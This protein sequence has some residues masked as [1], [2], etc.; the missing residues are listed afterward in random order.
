MRTGFHLTMMRATPI[1]CVLAAVSTAA[2]VGPLRSMTY[3]RAVNFAFSSESS[4]YSPVGAFRGYLRYGHEVLVVDVDT[5]TI[6]APGPS[7]PQAPIVVRRLRVSAMLATAG[8]ARWTA[9]SESPSIP[10]VDSLRLGQD[11]VLTRI[12]FTVS[13]PANIDLRDAWLVF[14]LEGL[15]P[16]V[17]SG[18]DT[19]RTFACDTKNLR[20]R[21]VRADVRVQE[22]RQ[23]YLSA[24]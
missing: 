2:C 19:V 15:A 14:K 9:V 23:N 16:T 22:M 20:G 5:A 4:S 12:R 13:V 1:L 11:A 3:G 18:A 10:V 24:C 21:S 17:V 6:R 7:H 8:K